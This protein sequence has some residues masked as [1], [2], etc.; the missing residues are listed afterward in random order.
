MTDMVHIKA[1][2]RRWN[3]QSWVDAASKRW[4]EGGWVDSPLYLAAG[5]PYWDTDPLIAQI[6]AGVPIA[7]VT[8]ATEFLSAYGLFGKVSFNAIGGKIVGDFSSEP[9]DPLAPESIR[10]L[11][12]FVREI[13]KYPP[14][15]IIASGLTEFT[16]IKNMSST[17][18]PTRDYGGVTSGSR[19]WVDV[20][21]FP[22]YN[23]TYWNDG[24]D[25]LAIL[26]HHELHHAFQDKWR[27]DFLHIQ[28]SWMANNP[29][30]YIGDNYL[31]LDPNIRP[32]GHARMYGRNAFFEDL[33]DIHAFLM[34]TSVQTVF[35]G[36]IAEDPNLATKV[37]MFKK[38]LA[39][40]S[41]EMGHP[42]YF[43]GMHHQ[44]PTEPEEPTGD[45]PLVA[46]NAQSS[47]SGQLDAALAAHA[48]DRETVEDLPFRLDT[49]NS[50]DLSGMFEGCVNLVEIGALDT[51]NATNGSNMFAGCI[52]LESIGPMDTS[53]MEAMDYMF[54]DCVS[55]AE[56][57]VGL[58]TSKATSTNS[59]FWYCESLVEVPQLDFS[60]SLDTG[61]LFAN[62]FSLRH[63]PSLD[64][65]LSLDATVMFWACYSLETVGFIDVHSAPDLDEFFNECFSLKTVEGVNTASAESLAYMFSQCHSLQSVGGTI[66]ARNGSWSPIMGMFWETLCLR[67]GAVKVLGPHPEM[68]LVEDSDSI[69]SSRLTQFPWYDESGNPISHDGVG[70]TS[71]APIQPRT[72]LPI[73]GAVELPLIQRPGS[74]EGYFL[75]ANEVLVQEV[76]KYDLPNLES[77]PFTI[78]VSAHED[79]STMFYGWGQM[80]HAPQVDTNHVT[81]TY[82]MFYAC[83]NL[84]TVPDLNTANVTYAA[85]MFY[86][87]RDLVDGN[88][89]LMGKNP[90][91][92]YDE[93]DWQGNVTT[94]IR[95]SGLTRA[96]FFD[97]AG[98]PI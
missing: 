6:N 54:G 49:S 81:S 51:S 82:G 20:M 48:T 57:P 32:P 23:S 31:S 85:D 67:D 29:S 74:D 77:V 11:A 83:T 34:T 72:Y 61:G 17:S 18:F 73:P 45:L 62:C 26:I 76:L 10:A 46:I 33:S 40:R 96:P 70:V 41:P 22:S 27:D 50:T 19:V 9:A 24:E 36:A 13:A 5:G 39:S 93:E 16:F 63:V 58:D 25:G 38:W 21:G 88:V 97:A 55:L 30:P 14:H 37:A 68:E 53:N 42:L 66:D 80:K 64:A 60:K 94:M 86:M 44:L 7:N 2:A 89:R 47:A 3:G 92:V 8:G 52:S 75:S 4:S 78:D 98:N 87:C 79:L 1:S 28:A 65:G 12:V 56:L 35:Q 71:P 43:R 90:D 84:E 15:F 91:V 69:D 95:G 59:M